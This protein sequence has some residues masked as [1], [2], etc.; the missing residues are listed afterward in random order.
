MKF[1]KMVY[2]VLVTILTLGSFTSLSMPIL[3][4]ET[5]SSSSSSQSSSVSSESSSSQASSATSS[6][7]ISD[8]KTADS[9]V[10]AQSKAA[11]VGPQ[12]DSDPVG[13][14]S[15]ANTP[16][17][18]S[19]SFL[20]SIFRKGFSIQPP[21]EQYIPV[22]NIS[23]AKFS[24]M[25]IETGI[26][27]L[28]QTLSVARWHWDAKLN[29]WVKDGNQPTVRAS[30]LL[31]LFGFLDVNDYS[32]SSLTEGAYYYQFMFTEA[33]TS[34]Y[35]NLAKVVVTPKPIAATNVDTNTD[36]SDGTPK[37]IYSDV[38][39]AANAILTP[40]NSTDMPAWSASST[41]DK[42]TFTPPSARA[43]K[44]RAG[45]GKSTA[46]GNTPDSYYTGKVNTDPKVPGIK[47]NYKVLVG[48]L[49]AKVKSLYVGGLPA[50]NAASDAG[51]TWAVGGLS[52][53]DNAT[54]SPNKWH[55]AWKFTDSSGKVIATPGAADGVTNVEGDVD[56]I[57]N[58]NTQAPL[59]FTRNSSFMTKAAVATS[60]GKSYQAQLTM[61]TQI[62]PADA[63]TKITIVSNKAE[64]QATS[65]TGYLTLDQVPSY[66]FDNITVSDIYNGTKNKKTAK[67][68]SLAVT[69]T[70]TDKYWALSAKMTKMTSDRGTQLE[71]EVK[72]LNLV[73]EEISVMVTDNNKDNLALTRA[74]GG[75]LTTPVTG[76]LYVNANH[77]TQL[78]DGERFS[79]TIT[80]TLTGDTPAT[81]KAE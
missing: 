64:L 37:V 27:P 76:A 24:G 48:T 44:I 28:Y 46:S 59:T 5:D 54:A 80:W 50:Y 38:D 39:Y 52:D 68:S 18:D 65:A 74:K 30:G 25:R 12:A 56:N 22:A 42:L 45:N 23:K 14:P 58:L 7:T 71:N 55:Y 11:T 62:D 41:N 17:K 79:S 2:L 61:S 10:T 8:A 72:I 15:G 49:A 9:S 26:H 69:D 3:A 70:R 20:L 75:S 1:K 35:S 33:G 29:T 47:A 6:S 31:G 60:A 66:N 51:G 63:K 43:T 40:N 73:N 81:K 53:L 57:A 4:A 78:T 67:T 77:K 19:W 13:T 36:N 32:M 34:Y 21:S 16:S